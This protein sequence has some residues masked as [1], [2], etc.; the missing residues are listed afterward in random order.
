MMAGPVDFHGTNARIADIARRTLWR[1]SSI[2]SSTPFQCLSHTKPTHH[3]TKPEL[4]QDRSHVMQTTEV[5][6]NTEN[7][8]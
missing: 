1:H 7:F 2:A 5:S 3:T 8:E 4:D 6:G